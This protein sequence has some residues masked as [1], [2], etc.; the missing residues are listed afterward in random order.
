M[1]GTSTLTRRPTWPFALPIAAAAVVVGLPALDASASGRPAELIVGDL[2]PNGQE[3]LLAL[4][5]LATARGVLLRRRVAYYVVLTL[6]VLSSLDALNTREPGRLLLL[7]A[8]AC[9]FFRFRGEFT[10]SPS[11][12]RT[13]V[14]TGLITYGLAILYGLIIMAAER[15]H[16]TPGPSLGDIGREILAGLTGSGPGPVR[17]SGSPDHWFEASLGILGGGGLL[18]MLITVLTPAPPPPAGTEEERAEAARLVDDGGSDTLAPFILR[19]DKS[20][21][22]SPD[23]RAVIGY[24][25]LFGVAA[26]GGDP[27][28]DPRSYPAAVAEFAALAHRSGW[29]MAVLGARADLLGLWHRYGLR[30]VGV[31]D[32]VLLTPGEFGLSGRS[33][34]NVRQAVQ[35]TR[36]AGVTTEVV[37]EGELSGDDR[38]R[39]Q[40]VATEAMGGAEE[41]GFSM[42]LDGLLTGKHASPIVVVARDADG[43][44]VGFQRYLPSACGRRLSLDAMRRS[45]DSAN[46]LNERMIADI[47]AH[48]REHGIDEVSLN[49]AAF[50]ELLDT[51]ERGALEQGGY[52]LIHLLDPFIKVESLYLFNRKFRPRYVP[53]SVVFPSWASIV[54]VALVLLTLEFGRWHAASEAD[55][56]A[57]PVAEDSYATWPTSPGW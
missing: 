9:A 33:M 17:F 52:R 24:R 56:R 25:V 1:A 36:N 12:V 42:N 18:A 16:I 47:M 39:L 15:H 57:K 43:T 22:F 48:A 53:R 28:G 2:F 50:R 10:T 5:M 21:V 55:R 44:P 26:A 32:E 37:H 51:A 29:R 41:R 7:V 11:R 34:R 40:V 30:S 49:F 6:A 3:L 13:A 46:G 35:R 14:T 27:A 23:R 8:A 4:V 38:A 45:P 54:P 19:S 31:G 20:Y